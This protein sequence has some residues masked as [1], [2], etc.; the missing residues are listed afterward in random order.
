[1]IILKD[2]IKKLR[3]EMDLTQK[4]FADKLGVSR[5][6]IASYETGKSN[7]GDTA[8]SLIC[9]TFNVN[10]SWLR[11]GTGEMFVELDVEDQ[12]ITAFMEAVL[13]EGKGSFRRRVILGLSA[14]DGDGW[15]ALEQFLGSVCHEPQ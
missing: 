1:M 9:T 12:R 10:E 15:K 11:D 2:R 4:E 3:R 5:N 14:M 13:E 6:N 8:I 7:L